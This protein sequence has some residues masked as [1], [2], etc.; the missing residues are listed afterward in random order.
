MKII[1]DITSKQASLLKFI[2]ARISREGRPPTI[3]EIGKHFGFR[4]TGTTRDHLASLVKKGYLQLTP[5]QSRSIRLSKPLVFRIPVLGRIV[6]G[7]PDLALEEIDEYLSL[8]EFLPSEDREVFAL[9]VKGDSM[10]P[11]GIHEGDVALIRRQ[12]LADDGDVVAAL[13]D[14]EATIKTLRKKGK[15]FYLE[16]ANKSYHEIHRPFTIIGKV[17]AVIKKF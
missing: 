17:I 11:K 16:P 10:D 12:R 4:S 5:R 1:G 9:K 6:A 15:D 8:D 14:H 7:M 3:R 13:L 2:Q